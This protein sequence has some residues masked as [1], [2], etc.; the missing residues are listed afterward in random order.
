MTE[1]PET[2]Q[3]ILDFVRAKAIN[4]DPM[5]TRAEIAEYLGCG[6]S[7]HWLPHLRKLKD[8]GL[9]DYVPG[10]VRSLRLLEMLDAERRIDAA[11]GRV[12]EH[13]RQNRGLIKLE[14]PQLMQ[15][16]DDLERELRK[17]D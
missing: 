2:Q 13:C 4:G 9:I 10:R 16:V 6:S 7:T 5:P 11:A 12:V 15:L 8:I 1:L 3:Q 14:F 17:S